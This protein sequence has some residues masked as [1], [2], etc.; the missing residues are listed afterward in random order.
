M[1]VL[2][3]CNLSFSSPLTKSREKERIWCEGEVDLF[4]KVLWSN[5]L[6]CCL[7]ISSSFHRV[8]ACDPLTNTS[9]IHQQSCSA[10]SLRT[11]DRDQH[12][13]H[14]LA[15]TARPQPP[16]LVSRRDPEEH[17]TFLAVP[18]SGK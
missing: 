2:K 10:D 1:M 18:L 4:R 3:C 8:A 9:C 6:L 7:E 11:V 17:Q 12:C 14:S 13:W 5:S 16:A 15:E